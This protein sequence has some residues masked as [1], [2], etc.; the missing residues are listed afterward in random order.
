MSAAVAHDHAYRSPTVLLD[1]AVLFPSRGG[2]AL[3]ALLL[4]GVFADAWLWSRIALDLCIADRGAHVCAYQLPSIVR[5]DLGLPGAWQEG[6]RDAPVALPA[7]LLLGDF[8]AALWWV[9]PRT[10]HVDPITRML[11]VHRRRWPLR[12]T[13]ARIHLDDIVLVH[14]KRSFLLHA[15]ALIDRDGVHHDVTGYRIGR[16][17]QH[18]LTAAIE[19]SIE[20]AV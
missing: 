13:R 14:V 17:H 2:L 10:V 15:V 5:G 11:I 1:Q 16:G 7:L 8:L 4:V 18:R 3:V 6:W 9:R 12:P 20:R 19:A